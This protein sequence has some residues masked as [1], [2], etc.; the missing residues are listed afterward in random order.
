MRLPR[1][2]LAFLAIAWPSIASDA[3]AGD[4]PTADRLRDQDVNVRRATTNEIRQADRARRREALP[5]LVEVLLKEKDGQVRLA[6]LDTITALGPDAEPAISALV[7][8]LRTD[9]GGQRSEES[10]QD[11]RSALALASIGKPAVEP[12]R[13]LLKERKESVRAEV[14]MGL[15]RIGPDAA[16]TVPDLI[17]LLGDASERIRREASRS[18]GLIGP[19]AIEALVA[20]STD[21]N[22]VVREG[23]AEALGIQPEPDE[24]V[25]R[26]VLELTRD[27]APGVRAAAI[28]TLAKLKLADDRL[29]PIVLENLRHDD[30][31]VRLAVVRLLVEGRTLMPRLGSELESLLTADRDGVASHAAYLLGQS[32]PEAA[33]RLLNALRSEGSRIDPIAGALAQIGRPAVE[34][35]SRAIEAPEPRVR[36][37]AALALGQVRPLGPDTA[38]RLT[39]GLADPDPEVRAAFLTAIGGLGPR[40]A[41][42]VPAVRNLLHDPSPEIRGRAIEVLV[43]S[44]PRD[45]RLVGDLRSLL[46]DADPKVQRRAIDAL[47]DLGPTGREALMTV[48]GRLGSADSEVRFAA[49]QMVESHGP[50]GTSAIPGLAQMLGDPAPKNRAIAAATLGKFGKEAQSAFPSFAT[51]LSDDDATVREAAASAVGSLGLEAETVRPALAKALRDE[52]TEVRR[53]ATR[54]ITRLGPPGAILVPDVILM[55]ARKENARSVDRLL[56]PFERTGP[57]A[58]SIPELVKLLEHDQVPVRL[59]AIKFLGLGGRNAREALPALERLGDDPSAEVRQQAKSACEQIRKG[60]EAAGKA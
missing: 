60:L 22:R 13:G 8:T 43:H 5:A 42:S 52:K 48:I 54:G 3:W 33:P 45:E 39:L 47:R 10:H 44:A 36:R 35:L 29:M 30:D 7:Q 57:D 40:A 27:G 23:V 55:A 14:V 12:L 11:Y 41:E 6:V 37:G 2:K 18:L 24:R 34:L 32:G 31:R 26:A 25:R 21:Q 15:G 46:D 51:L 4:V 19:P 1:W 17:P 9:Y 59:L 49:A 56:R 28:R 16:A 50:A 20:A 58:R 53:A 38:R